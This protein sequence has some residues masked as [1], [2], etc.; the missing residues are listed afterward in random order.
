MHF[1][2]KE[3]AIEVFTLGKFDIVEKC[4]VVIINEWQL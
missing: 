4:L 1:E 2:S 3:N